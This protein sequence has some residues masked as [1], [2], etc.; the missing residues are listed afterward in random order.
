MIF[1]ISYPRGRPAKS[2]KK[3]GASVQIQ[4]RRVAGTEAFWQDADIN[5]WVRVLRRLLFR[6]SRAERHLIPHKK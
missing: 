1:F 6:G 3:Y 4:D 2:G 5:Q